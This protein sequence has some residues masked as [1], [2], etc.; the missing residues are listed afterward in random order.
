[1]KIDVLQ[2]RFASPESRSNVDQFNKRSVK[3]VIFKG[4]IP[5]AIAGTVVGGHV[6]GSKYDEW[7]QLKYQ[8]ERQ[9]EEKGNVDEDEDERDKSTEQDRGAYEDEEDDD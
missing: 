3:S 4:L 7:R 1:M 5:W 8:R 2:D 6:L 9:G